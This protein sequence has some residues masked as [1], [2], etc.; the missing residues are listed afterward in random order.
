LERKA[1]FHFQKMLPNASKKYFELHGV[2]SLSRPR[3][4][5]QEAEPLG[6]T[7]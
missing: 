2:A 4:V 7:I 3:P 1:K 6:E 5:I